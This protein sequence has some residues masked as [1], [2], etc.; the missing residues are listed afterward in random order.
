MVEAGNISFGEG[1][2]DVGGRGGSV[3]KA[4]IKTMVEG[5]EAGREASG[6]VRVEA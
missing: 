5:L 3:V 1:Q 6:E 2:G 4:G